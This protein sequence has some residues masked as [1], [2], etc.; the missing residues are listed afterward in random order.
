MNS[1][2][3]PTYKSLLNSGELE[4]RVFLLNEMLKKCE[5]CPRSCRVNRQENK[6]GFCKTGRKSVVAS[7]CVHRGEE[8]VISGFKGSGTIFFANCN[9][10]CVYC[11]NY[12][13][14]QKWVE[15]EGEVDKETLAE[16]YLELQSR[17]VHNINWVSPSHV[18]PQAVEAL[19]IAAKKGLNIPIVYNSNGYDSLKTLKLLEGIV[20]IYMPDFKYFDD[21]VAKELSNVINYSYY[22]K[23][24]IKEMFYQVGKLFVDQDGIAK[25]GLLVRHLVLPNNL[26]QSEEVIKY[27]ANNVSKEITISLMAQYYPTNLAKDDTRLNRFIT[28]KE[29]LKA[30]NALDLSG[31]EDGFI[32]ELKSSETYRPNFKKDGHPF[33]D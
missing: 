24:A 17:G 1:P 28:L 23:E 15:G 20:D 33:E 16:I 4:K 9:L 18:V 27:L 29:Y 12:E 11:Q 31:I 26:S 7:Y 3:L 19:L 8:P 22:A 25:R 21:D 13:I 5:V 32:Q 6:V 14:S 10:A 30:L 2:F